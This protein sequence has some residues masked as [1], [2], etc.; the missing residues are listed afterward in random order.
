MNKIMLAD[1]LINPD[2]ITL[3]AER[4]LTFQ[5]ELPSTAKGLKSLLSMPEY[6]TEKFTCI[7]VKVTEGTRY[8][9]PTEHQDFEI[10]PIPTP[11]GEYEVYSFYTVFNDQRLLACAKEYFNAV[12]SEQYAY[13]GE[14]VNTLCNMGME[15][16]F[17]RWVN[18]IYLENNM[19]F[20]PSIRTKQDFI[21]KYLNASPTGASIPGS[22][23][24]KS[25]DYAAF[26]SSKV[27]KNFVWKCKRCGMVYD[28][29]P[30][31]PDKLKTWSKCTNG[32][33][34]QWEAKY[35]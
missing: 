15:M 34:H 7:V 30:T 11:I 16:K 33:K 14:K 32:D 29:S 26:D 22:E 18:R 31:L 9:P 17:G 6:R 8:M 35:L 19:H 2:D 3:I 13:S 23:P 10:C 5:K 21:Q 27:N 24:P 12:S 4:T 25:N 20:D 1:H 28:K